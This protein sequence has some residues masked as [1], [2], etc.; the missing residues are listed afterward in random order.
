MEVIKVGFETQLGQLKMLL[1]EDRNLWINQIDL[2][3]C[4][5]L[6]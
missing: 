2:I 1:N 6:Y 3:L 4:K 5:N